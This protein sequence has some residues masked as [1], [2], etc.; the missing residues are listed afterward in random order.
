MNPVNTD[1]GAAAGGGAP[2]AASSDMFAVSG[3]DGAEAV[4]NGPRRARR[5]KVNQEELVG[6][7]LS[8]IPLVGFFLFGFIPMVT[9]I[10][11]AFCD[12]KGYSFDGAKFIWFDNF[13]NVLKDKLFR[14]S[15]VNTL[16]MALSMPISLVLSLVIAYLLEKDIRCR[17]AFRTIYFIPMVCSVVATTLMWKWIFNT[18]YGIINQM[19]GWTGENAVDWLGDSATYTPAV[20]VMSVWGG[21][22]FSIILFSAALTN[23]NSSLVEAAKMDGAGAFR[24]FWHITLPALSPTTFYLFVTGFIGA[25]QA[26][27]ITN[28]LSSNGGPNNDG[29]TMV[30][31]LYQRA[32]TYVN[33]MGEASATAW[34][35]A[36]MIVIIT[37]INFAVS[38]LWVSYD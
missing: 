11:M 20:I 26:F 1:K 38:K 25:L 33:T 9:A 4:V 3:A 5:F 35:L 16:Y 8:V 12:I 37:I 2:E 36:I 30:F 21:T 27:A 18:Q 15:I 13:A 29:I 10:G 22:G 24:C 17:K 7:L 31:Y 32:F 19:F 23:V 6:L 34:I 28:V 14:D